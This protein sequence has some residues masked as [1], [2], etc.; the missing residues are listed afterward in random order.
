M[1]TKRDVDNALMKEKLLVQQQVADA[2]RKYNAPD[3]E[4][5]GVIMWAELPEN[6]KAE[7]RRRRPELATRLEEKL[8]KRGK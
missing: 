2:E 5:A 1:I 7:I 8:K 6:V 3:I 4:Q